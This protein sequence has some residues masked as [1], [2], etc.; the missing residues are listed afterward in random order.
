MLVGSGLSAGLLVFESLFWTHLWALSPLPPRSVAAGGFFGYPPC[1]HL[2]QV[3][4]CFATTPSVYRTSRG[5]LLD[6]CQ[7][8]WANLSPILLYWAV[9]LVTYHTPHLME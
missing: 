8:C 5:L 4:P 7:L 6:S 2:V 9:L 3:P 1:L